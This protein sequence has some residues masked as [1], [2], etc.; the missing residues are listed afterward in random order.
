MKKLGTEKYLRTYGISSARPLVA[1]SLEGID[2]AVV[3]PALAE[4][5]SLFRTLS[6]IACNPSDELRRT[7]VI[8][9]VNNHR[10]H[11][12]AEAEIT[13]NRETLDILKAIVSGNLESSICR[14]DMQAD[15]RRIAGSDLRPAYID[16]SSPG[17]EIPDRDGGVGT[18]RK[19][20][21]DAALGIAGMGMNKNGLIYCLDA[22]TLVEKNYLSAV[23]THF[24]ETGDLAAVI[25]Y[26]HQRP[27]DPG[28]QA[29]ICCYEFFLRSYVMGLTYA[30]SPYAF[31]SIGSTIACT[32]QGYVGVRGMNR[33]TAAEDFYFLN[34]LAKNCRVRT[35]VDTTVFPSPRIS[36]RVPFGTGRSMLRFVTGD[37]NEYHC[38][39]PKVFMILREW[40]TAIERDPDRSPETILTEVRQIHARLEDYLRI[41]HFDVNWRLIRQ[42]SRDLRNLRRQFHVWFDGV[43]TVR[44]IRHLSRHEF[45]LVPMFDGLTELIDLMG[46]PFPTVIFTGG[47]PN[48]DVQYT[49]LSALRSAFPHS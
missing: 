13:D 21:M 23:H 4:K 41:N 39:D 26:A 35:V 18:A 48:L 46:T 38:Y 1:S 5:S 8:C 11:I 40:L 14:G 2:H 20:G 43:K 47:I 22:D 30:G 17:L 45:P 28:L 42:N 9:V 32:V 25:S 33:R 36:T 24:A 29:A 16:A 15:L 10:P 19:I 27:V 12:A 31:H 44:L 6:S 37:T 34:K 3:I 49:V 7:L